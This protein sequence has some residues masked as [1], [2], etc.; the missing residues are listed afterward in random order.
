LRFETWWNVYI[1]SEIKRTGGLIGNLH[2]CDVLRDD[3]LVEDEISSV[4]ECSFANFCFSSEH[5]ISTLQ[6]IPLC[7]KRHTLI[8]LHCNDGMNRVTC[9]ERHTAGVE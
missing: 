1:L 4:T 3:E 6:F 8:S 9:V 2:D 7:N 5:E